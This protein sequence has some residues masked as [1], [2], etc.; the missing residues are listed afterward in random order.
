MSLKEKIVILVSFYMFKID[1]FLKLLERHF[2]LER[3]FI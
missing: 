2:W 1:L 3:H